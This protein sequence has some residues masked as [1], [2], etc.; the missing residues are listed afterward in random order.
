MGSTRQPTSMTTHSTAWLSHY[1]TR[2]QHPRRAQ[3]AS[4]C[5]SS[6]RAVGSAGV[7]ACCSRM[8]TVSSGW[9]ATTPAAPPMPPAARRAAYGMILL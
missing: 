2:A 8:R 9:P 4:S 6:V 3:L 1:L 5:V 7:R